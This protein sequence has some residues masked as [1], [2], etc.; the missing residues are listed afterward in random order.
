M[1]NLNRAVV[2]GAVLAFASMVAT[3][4][5]A[6]VFGGKR[7]QTAPD[8]PDCAPPAA[9]VCPCPASDAHAS[10]GRFGVGL[11][12]A[13]S[14]EGRSNALVSPF[15]VGTVLAML[16]QGATEPVRL[17]IREMLGTG[18]PNPADN[19]ARGAAGDAT[20]DVAGRGDSGSAAAGSGE[21][22]T[23]AD[24]PRMQASGPI[25]ALPC[26]LA[27]VLGAAGEDEGVELRIANAAFA[28][29]RLDLFPSF[30][31]VLADRFGA[32]VERFDFADEAAVDRINAWV[33]RKTEEVI[34]S[35]VSHLEPD[36]VLVLANA[37]YFRGIWARQ[38]DAARTMPL[39]FHLQ[40]DKVV[41]VPTMQANDL[42][43]RY[44]ENGDYRALVLPYGGGDFVAV[45]VL[46]REG[47]A[48]AAALRGLAADPSWLGESGFRRASGY[49]AL[50]RV[51]LHGEAS[52]LPTLRAQGLAT[53]IDDANAF[54]GIASPAPALS[55]VAHRTMLVLDEQ[56]TEAA[57]ATAAIMTTRAAIPVDGGFEMIVDR[58]FALALRHRRTGALL[59]TAWVADPSGE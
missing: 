52:L 59:F 48:P 41:D 39:P 57:A 49:L 16:A 51:T 20:G 40:P 34:P 17:S 28:D 1:R 14:G 38:F 55:R 3:P 19:A 58:P 53:A 27:A 12:G 11:L 9:V 26:G 42:R 13:L 37:M 47:L 7:Q 44:R 32:R 4:A 10:F 21:S 23:D 43:A 8:R 45:V 50:P 6:A 5:A 35:L 46:P 22:G 24:S 36:D 25:D 33:A 56:G 54:A 15:G 18:P 29:L 30:A 2:A 31:A